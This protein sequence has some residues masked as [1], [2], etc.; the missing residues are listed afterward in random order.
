[1]EENKCPKCGSEEVTEIIYG[2]LTGDAETVK[3]MAEGKVKLGGM[4]M[5]AGKSPTKRCVSC[6]YG[7]GEA[8][9]SSCG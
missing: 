2:Q 9:K 8:D 1:M 5:I 6:G 3:K 4:C 7:W